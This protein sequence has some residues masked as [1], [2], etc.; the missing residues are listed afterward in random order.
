M[1]N[2]EMNEVFVFTLKSILSVCNKTTSGN[3][4]HN[5]ATIKCKCRDMIDLY[6]RHPT[7][8]WHSVAD[9]DEPLSYVD[10]L[11]SYGE[12]LIDKGFMLDNRCVHLDGEFSPMLDIED[13]KYWIEIPQ[14]PTQG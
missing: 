13:V 2:N 10:C 1:T 8:P 3:V 11:F 5:I 6:S 4:S 12:G 7:T 14:L 9:G